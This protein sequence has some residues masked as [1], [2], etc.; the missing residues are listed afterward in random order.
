MINHVVMTGCYYNIILIEYEQFFKYP[1][2]K[3]VIF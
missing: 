2:V 1:L 3:N